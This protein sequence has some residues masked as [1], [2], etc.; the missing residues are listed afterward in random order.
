MPRSLSEFLSSPSLYPVSLDS[1][2]QM[3]HFI[4]MS[5]NSY[6][7]SSFLDDRALRLTPDTYTAPLSQLQELTSNW[8]FPSGPMDFILHGAFCCSTLLARY[9]EL[10]PHCFVLKEPSLLV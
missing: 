4:L 3:I 6:Q 5:R 1:S 10:I 7:E 9:L 8:H 2:S